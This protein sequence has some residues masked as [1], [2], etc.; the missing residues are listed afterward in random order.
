MKA[1]EMLQKLN[2]MKL[3]TLLKWRSLSAPVRTP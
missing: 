2:D 1:M 3:S